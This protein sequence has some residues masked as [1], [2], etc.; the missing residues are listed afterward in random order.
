MN[1][2]SEVKLH[3][4]DY[5]RTIRLRA[6]LIAL[7]FLLVMITAGVTVYFLPREYFSKVTMEVKPDNSSAIGDIFSNRAGRAGSDP[8]FISTQ[9][10]IL[11]KTEILYPVIESLKL[12]EAWSTEGRKMELQAVYMKLV[13][14]LQLREIRNTGLI[15]VG[16]YSVERQEAA[17]IANTIAVVYQ[18]KRLSDLQKNIDKGL[19]QLKDEV[20]KQRKLVD[21]SAAEMS[22]IRTRDGIIDPNPLDFGS[23]AGEEDRRILNI[24]ADVNVAKGNVSKLRLQVEQIMNLK[25]EELKEALRVLES[26]D[27]TV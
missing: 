23:T 2:A 7:A 11:Q 22:K 14:M 8:M 6:G 17:N 1:D 4:L 13:R 19:E 20:E 5:W 15:E 9:F 21:G 18:Q 24:E 3:F 25:P 26:P 16:A 27:Q 12:V 10:N